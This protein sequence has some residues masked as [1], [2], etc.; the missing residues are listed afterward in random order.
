[1]SVCVCA[2]MRV[3][4]RGEGGEVVTRCGGADESFRYAQ[5]MFAKRVGSYTA[6]RHEQRTP[7]LDSQSVGEKDRIASL[8]GGESDHNATVTITRCA[9]LGS[10][11]RTS[12]TEPKASS[13]H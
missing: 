7:T 3:K 1:M 2:C 8:P 5:R 13:L 6:S 12:R 10:E 9:D 4:N 11:R